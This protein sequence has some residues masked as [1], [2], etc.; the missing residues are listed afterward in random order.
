[1]PAA[2]RIESVETLMTGRCLIIVCIVAHGTNTNKRKMKKVGNAGAAAYRSPSP[3]SP[4]RYFDVC[5]LGCASARGRQYIQFSSIRL[6]SKSQ[7]IATQIQ[8]QSIMKPTSKNMP[9][10]KVCNK[11]NAKCEDCLIIEMLLLVMGDTPLVIENFLRVIEIP[12]SVVF[13]FVFVVG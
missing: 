9:K 8:P 2:V 12:L 5:W 10:P 6:P 1:M 7:G 3:G 11:L 13:I 4:T